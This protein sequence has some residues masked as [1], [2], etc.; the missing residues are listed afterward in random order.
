MPLKMGGAEEA[1]IASAGGLVT[2]KVGYA[3]TGKAALELGQEVI[4]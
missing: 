1:T 4:S 2:V 3:M